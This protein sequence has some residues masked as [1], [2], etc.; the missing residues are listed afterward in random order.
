MQNHDC[1]SG[2]LENIVGYVLF[3][4]GQAWRVFVA[5]DKPAGADPVNGMP[6]VEGLG[7][8]Q[9]LENTANLQIY[10][11]CGAN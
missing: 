3:G 1:A 5:R 7:C 4:I 10:I 8:H 2:E 9:N 11:I 6:F